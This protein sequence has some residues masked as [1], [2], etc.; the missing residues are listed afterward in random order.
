MSAVDRLKYFTRSFCVVIREYFKRTDRI[1]LFRELHSWIKCL[2]RRTFPKF[3]S[4]KIYP[5][6]IEH[7]QQ[8]CQRQQNFAA[9]FLENSVY[10][11]VL[12]PGNSFL[13]LKKVPSKEQEIS[14]SIIWEARSIK[15]FN[16]KIQPKMARARTILLLKGE[17]LIASTLFSEK[18]VYYNEIQ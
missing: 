9:S 3:S 17:A 12:V 7:P 11:R 16:V 2:K 4:I 6:I 18:F 14:L 5:R 1:N 13:V 15:H 8:S 10:L